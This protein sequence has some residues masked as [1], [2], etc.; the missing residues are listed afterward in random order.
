[1]T[2]P[3][4]RKYLLKR[5]F[6]DL[7]VATI[8]GIPYDPSQ[9]DGITVASEYVFRGPVMQIGVTNIRFRTLQGV[10]S[11][12]TE[13]AWPERPPGYTL[14]SPSP[15]EPEVRSQIGSQEP[16]RIGPPGS[17]RPL[18]PDLYDLTKSQPTDRNVRPTELL[19]RPRET[20]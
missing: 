11:P 5:R 3:E 9:T 4:H 10:P 12:R 6:R 20:D 17:L 2:S 13:R 14:A 16:I 8:R 7:G 1:M 19:D 18:T 15:T